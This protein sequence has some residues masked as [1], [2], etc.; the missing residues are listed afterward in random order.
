MNENKKSLHV[1]ERLTWWVSQRMQQYASKYICPRFP[2]GSDDVEAR[3]INSFRYSEHRSELSQIKFLYPRVFL[4]YMVWQAQRI[5]HLLGSTVFSTQR[6]SVALSV[7]QSHLFLQ[8]NF[9]A[10]PAR[11]FSLAR[12]LRTLI[13]K[14]AVHQESAPSSSSVS[15]YTNH[16][17]L[18]KFSWPS[19]NWRVNPA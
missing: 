1:Q 15:G 13:V 3:C 17:V 10:N 4:T 18:R 12:L 2:R 14:S 9:K 11:W 16:S 6:K 7:Q 5:Q 19:A 8:H